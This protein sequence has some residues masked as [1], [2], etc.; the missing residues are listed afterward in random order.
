[1]SDDVLDRFRLDGRVA[2]VTG[3]ARGLGRAIA[4]ALASAGATLVVTSRD[5]EAADAAAVGLARDSQ[6]PVHGMAL[7]VTEPDSVTELVQAAVARFGQIDILVNNAGM[8]HRGSL[9]ELTG[10]QWDDVLDTNLK[11]TW[12][13]CQAVHPV[14]RAAGWG[15]VI[16]I[17]SMFSEVALPNRTP[18]VASKGGVTALTRALA[19]EFAG[20]GINVNALCPGPFK[21]EMHD[22]AA[23]AGMLSAI[24]LG[25]FGDPVEL[26]P[27]AVFLASEASS[28]ITGATLAIDGG[29]T[30]R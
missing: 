13:C 27:V 1:M 12:L 11:G 23:R 20:D 22:Q 6:N 28:F 15:R 2:L 24:P 29:Y 25:R 7:D 8:T 19:V 4:S 16:N 5:P 18:Y 3:A 14:M 10:A 21:T 26:G 17:S 30:A 9:G